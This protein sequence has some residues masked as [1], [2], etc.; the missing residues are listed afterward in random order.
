MGDYKYFFLLSLNLESA[1][2]GRLLNLNLDLILSQLIWTGTG[3][4]TV[5]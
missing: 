2:G 4:G 1:I 3:A 5:I